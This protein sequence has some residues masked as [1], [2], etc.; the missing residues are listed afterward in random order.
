MIK[1]ANR[2]FENMAEFKYLGT[3]A[4]NPKFDSEGN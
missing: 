3:A 2:C 4:R 1:S